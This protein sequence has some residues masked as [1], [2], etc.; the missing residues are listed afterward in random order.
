MQTYE[1]NLSIHQS[2]GPNP[3]DSKNI[4]ATFKRMNPQ[5]FLKFKVLDLS[6]CSSTRFKLRLGFF[7]KVRGRSEEKLIHHL[8]SYLQIFIQILIPIS[9]SSSLFFFLNISFLFYYFLLLLVLLVLFLF[10]YSILSFSFLF[11]ILLFE[12]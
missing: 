7:I 11:V 12:T 6:S 5:S 9:Y 1:L 8:H 3:V 4:L 2:P 10:F